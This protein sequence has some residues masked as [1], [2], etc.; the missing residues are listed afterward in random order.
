MDFLRSNTKDKL[1]ASA[2][3]N[4]IYPLKIKRDAKG[5]TKESFPLQNILM[6]PFIIKFD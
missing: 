1:P 5:S 3:I 4:Q 2:L 6:F